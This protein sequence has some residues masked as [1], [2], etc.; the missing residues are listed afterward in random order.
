MCYKGKIM[1]VNCVKT[2]LIKAIHT[3]ITLLKI[4]IPVYTV[5]V[6]IRY[7]PVLAMLENAFAPFMK[8][9]GLP[10]EGIIPLIAGVFTDE[11]GVLAALKQLELTAAQITTIA[12]MTLVAHTIPVESALGKKIGLQIAPFVAFR[13]VFAILIGLLTCFIGGLFL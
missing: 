13:L 2:G 8:F 10:G 6:L 4:V 3:A 1:L 7:T 9:F 12:M 11:Y 5:V